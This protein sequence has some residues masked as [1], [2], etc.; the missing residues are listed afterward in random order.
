MGKITKIQA[1]K[2][3]ADVLPSLE[4][5]WDAYQRLT[6]IPA[7]TWPEQERA[8]F[9]LAPAIY[10]GNTVG[11][12]PAMERGKARTELV[13]HL[14]SYSKKWGKAVFWVDL[15][16]YLGESTVPRNG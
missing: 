9:D 1:E 7:S 11:F 4:V 15:E 2:L 16:G 3:W 12:T 5:A 13:D 8:L 6:G 14:S 10:A